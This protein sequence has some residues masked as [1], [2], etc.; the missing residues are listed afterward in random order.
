MEAESGKGLRFLCIVQ[1]TGHLES[2]EQ[3]SPGNLQ[4]GISSCSASQ[5]PLNRMVPCTDEKY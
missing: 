2:A 1:F 5:L 4:F 3:N